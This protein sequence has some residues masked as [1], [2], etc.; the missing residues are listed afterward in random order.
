ME[1]VLVI[2]GE[3]NVE[4]LTLTGSLSSLGTSNEPDNLSKMNRLMSDSE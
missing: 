3:R 4:H 2:I 1:I